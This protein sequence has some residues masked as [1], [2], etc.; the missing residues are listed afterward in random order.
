MDASRDWYDVPLD[1]LW[2]VYNAWRQGEI[3]AF[4]R[5]VTTGQ[6][7]AGAMGGD[8]KYFGKVIE[9]GERSAVPSPLAEGSDVAQA[10]RTP[11]LPYPVPP[12]VAA[13]LVEA[14]AAGLLEGPALSSWPATP[15][16]L[17]LSRIWGRIE[18]AV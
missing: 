8:A 11:E 14:M 15:E 13:G 4:A 2:A 16:G 1:C 7:A 6:L 17:P 12:A 5:A 10:M 3:R 9:Q 18:A